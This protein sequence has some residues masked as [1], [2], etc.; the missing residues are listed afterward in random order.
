MF[1]HSFLFWVVDNCFLKNAARPSSVSVSFTCF[2]KYLH[3]QT[4]ECGFLHLG[5]R[6]VLS[7]ILL[8]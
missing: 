2:H 1:F 7:K 8:F 3:L 6:G 5:N 4:Q